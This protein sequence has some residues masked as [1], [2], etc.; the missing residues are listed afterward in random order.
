MAGL[1]Y[2]G[3][4]ILRYLSS[5]LSLFGAACGLPVPIEPP[6]HGPIRRLSLL[7]PYMLMLFVPIELLSTSFSSFVSGITIA[8]AVASRLSL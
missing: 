3:A 8:C 7:R 6:W 5:L 2:L 4:H 1:R